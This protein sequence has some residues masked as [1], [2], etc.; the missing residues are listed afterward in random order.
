MNNDEQIK[1]TCENC[2]EWEFFE[3]F[4]YG[5]FV[6]QITRTLLDANEC[7]NYFYKRRSWRKKEGGEQE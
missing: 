5:C 4:G 6:R 7:S 3:G 1:K 2:I